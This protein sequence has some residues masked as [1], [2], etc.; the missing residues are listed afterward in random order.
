ML[1]GRVAH[2]IDGDGLIV[3][4][5]DRRVN[6][7][8]IH[9]DAPA[10]VQAYGHQSRQSLIAICGG[11]L[12]KLESDGKDRNGRTL[13]RVTCGGTDAN[14][15]QVRR[16]MAWVFDRYT[17]PA[18]PLYAIQEETRAARRGLWADHEPVPRGSGG[19]SE[20]NARASRCGGLGIYSTSIG[21]CPRARHRKCCRESRTRGSVV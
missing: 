16:G 2:V 15:E 12:A 5:R 17:K 19:P 3:L 14:A 7:R 11:K 18:S 4:L 6:V 1:E 8:L 10:R 9:I 21:G 13:A 20:P